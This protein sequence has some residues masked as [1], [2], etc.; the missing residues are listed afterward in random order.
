GAVPKQVVGPFA[1][2]AE[3]ARLPTTA[4]S[5]PCSRSTPVL[6]IA[7]GGVGVLAVPIGLHAGDEVRQIVVVDHLT[8]AEDPRRLPEKFLDLPRVHRHLLG[9]LLA[10]IEEAERMVVRLAEE[11]AAPGFGQALEDV[12]HVRAELGPLVQADARDGIRDF[13][14]ALVPL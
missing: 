8:V 10:A 12:D 13:E 2:A 6:P 4:T 3:P 14:P 11:L 1:D 7:P 5:P 9:E